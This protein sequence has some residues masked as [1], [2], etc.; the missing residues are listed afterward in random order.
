MG[1]CDGF[2]EITI[3]WKWRLVLIGSIGVCFANADVG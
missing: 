3:Q 1:N 2:N